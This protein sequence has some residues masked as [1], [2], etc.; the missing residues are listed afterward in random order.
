MRSGKK[1]IRPSDQL[2]NEVLDSFHAEHGYLLLKNWNLPNAYC[3]AVKEHHSE[4]V[5]PNNTLL[6]IVRLSNKACNKLGIGMAEDPDIILAASQ[7]A[8]QLGLTEVFL[9]KLEIKLEDS[10]IYSRSA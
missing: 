3:N 1:E 6:N 10:F 4:E 9:A 2:L 7:E 5:D 8:N